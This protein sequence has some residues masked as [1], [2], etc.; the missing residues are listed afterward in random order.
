MSPP[1]N[2]KVRRSERT[3]GRIA[4]EVLQNTNVVVTTLTALA[5]LRIRTAHSLWFGVGSLVALLSAKILKLFIRQPRPAGARKFEKTYGM[6]ST[7]SSS[8]AFFGVYLSLSTLLLPLHPR[9]TSLL[10]FWD[11][12]ATRAVAEGPSHLVRWGQMGTRAVLA[13]IWVA[14]A[15]S[16]CWSRVRLGHHTRA[17][18]LAGIALGS[19]VAVVWLGLWLG[20]EQL[21]LSV[22]SG[23]PSWVAGGVRQRAFVLERVVEDAATV[24][25]EAWRSKDWTKLHQLQVI[26]IF[27]AFYK[28][29]L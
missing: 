16:V 15:G 2:T 20:G 22:K 11:F 7:H 18:V 27:S 12:L 14:G 6:P 4:L 29:E 1:T 28:D 3:A 10:P 17:Q 8:I 13:F 19:T 25:L 23:W 21:G 5:I 24:L 26:P 9:V